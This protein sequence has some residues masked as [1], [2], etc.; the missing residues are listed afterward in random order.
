MRGLT[1][2]EIARLP[3][4][5]KG[6]WGVDDERW[7]YP[8]DPLYQI[9]NG[10]SRPRSSPSRTRRRCRP[11]VLDHYYLCREIQDPRDPT[12]GH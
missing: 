2:P 12:C 9:L 6:T 5:Y 8:D 11:S 1:D 3:A 4:V 10:A 7:M